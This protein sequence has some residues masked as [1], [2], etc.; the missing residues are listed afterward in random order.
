M[1]MLVSMTCLSNLVRAADTTRT[2]TDMA[3]RTVTIPEKVTKVYSTNPIGTILMYTLA[4]DKL[5]GVNTKISSGEKNYTSEKYQQLPVLGGWF[6]GNTTGNPEVIL[7]AHPDLIINV[8]DINPQAISTAEKRQQ[9]LGVPVVIANLRLEEIDKS[10]KFLG[11]ILGEKKRAEELA[12]YCRKTVSNIIEKVQKIPQEQRKHVYYAEGSDGLLTDPEG[13]RHAE[14][15]DL[16][17]GINV[18]EVAMK[19]GAGRSEVSLEQIMLWN[20]DLIIVCNQKNGKDS[21]YNSILSDKKWNEIEAIKNNRIYAIPTEPFN[22]FDRPPSVNR[23]IGLKWLTNLLYPDVF[24][25]DIKAE[26]KEFYKLFYH[27]DLT[28]KE[29]KEI[30]KNAE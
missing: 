8:T 21:S 1:V 10:Y 30:L 12:L 22:W 17:G 20:P 19:H 18:A 25:I 9:Q 15:L 5:A 7:K 13:S 23:L 11:K 14:V 28:D 2:I 29:V 4:P 6:G 16:A 3:G 26:A 24:P 27:Y